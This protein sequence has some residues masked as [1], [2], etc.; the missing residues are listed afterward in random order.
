MLADVIQNRVFFYSQWN[1][2][3]KHFLTT[4]H[5]ANDVIAIYGDDPDYH[6]GDGKY[7]IRL[8]PDFALYDLLSER[9]YI[10]DMYAFSQAPAADGAPLVA[11]ENMEL[12]KDYLGFSNNTSYQDYRF[13]QVDMQA[14]YDIRLTRVPGMGSPVFYVKVMNSDSQWPAR[15]DNSHFESADHET[16]GDGVQ[17]LTLDASMRVGAW[18]LCAAHATSVQGDGTQACF[19]AMSVTCSDGKQCAYKLRIDQ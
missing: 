18:G 16:K 11:F 14:T 13:F 3:P 19:I 17:T 1:T 4:K 15:A 2:Y 6:L 8:R 7:Y 10:Y 9:Q 12:G 5:D